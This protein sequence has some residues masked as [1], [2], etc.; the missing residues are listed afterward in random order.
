MKNTAP[1]VRSL[2]ALNI[3][4]INISEKPIIDYKRTASTRNYT[5]PLPAPIKRLRNIDIQSVKE[6]IS[7]GL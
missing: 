1:K 6:L 2:S 3:I 7:R 4:I 5:K